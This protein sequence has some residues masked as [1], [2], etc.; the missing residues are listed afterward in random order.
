MKKEPVCLQFF[1]KK[2]EVLN[3][4]QLERDGSRAGIV[5]QTIKDVLESLV[6][7]NLVESDKIGS[8]NF[9]WSLPSRTYQTLSIKT[10]EYNKQIP[11]IKAEKDELLAS[12]TL[13]KKEKQETPERLEKL[14]KINS[15]KKVYGDK[16]K[17]N[18]KYAKNDPV[19]LEILEKRAANFKDEANKWTDNVFVCK[20]WM[21][22][23]YDIEEKRINEMYSI[24][25][26]LD[27]LP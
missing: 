10:E 13:A 25:E 8:A 23:K 9:Y 22:N 19:K 2:K 6:D 5:L 1:M 26:E 16:I 27:N 4:K 18:E 21:R 11:K 20:Q 15:L 14:E 17:E 7:D 12:I 24:P 3:L